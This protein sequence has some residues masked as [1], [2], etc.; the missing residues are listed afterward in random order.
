[1]YLLSFY[2]KQIPGETTILDK[3]VQYFIIILFFPCET[4]KCVYGWLVHSTQVW[5]QATGSPHIVL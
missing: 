2:D 3:I 1:M 4:V 5:A